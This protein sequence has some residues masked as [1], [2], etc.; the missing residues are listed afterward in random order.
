M[1]RARGE[2][3]RRLARKAPRWV[4]G[5]IGG[6]ASL[7]DVQLVRRLFFFFYP[8]QPAESSHIVSQVASGER[9]APP[10]SVPDERRVQKV[11]SEAAAVPRPS[12]LL[13]AVSQHLLPLQDHL[14]ELLQAGLQ[15]L[16]VHGRAALRVVQRGRAQLVQGQ[17]LLHLRDTHTAVREADNQS[18]ATQKKKLLRNTRLLTYLLT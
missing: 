12:S 8:P 2:V 17:H 5:C 14:V 13:L 16:A 11:R 7:S 9:G 15:A 18:A 4:G 3:G 1:S 6:G 10:P